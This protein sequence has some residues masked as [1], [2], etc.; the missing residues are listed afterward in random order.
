MSSPEEISN[1]HRRVLVLSDSEHSRATLRLTLRKAGYVVFDHDSAIG[2]TKAIVNHRAAAIIVELKE[3][4][5]SCDR[6]VTMLR[7]NSRLQGLVVVVLGGHDGLWLDTHPYTARVDA[8][9]LAEDAPGQLPGLLHR[10]LLSHSRLAATASSGAHPLQRSTP[11]MTGTT[12]GMISGMR[13]KISADP[14]SRS[15]MMRSTPGQA[16]GMMPKI[17]A[18]TSGVETETADWQRYARRRR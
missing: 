18:D 6:I 4:G 5:A 16:S 9:L 7:A 12:P 13:P 2:L 1:A 11:G 10:L 15:A 8:V 14:P 3:H 17:R